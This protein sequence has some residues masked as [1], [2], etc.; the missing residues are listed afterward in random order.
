MSP[1]LQQQQQRVQQLQVQQWQWQQQQRFTQGP[2]P[3]VSRAD[4]IASPSDAQN[5]RRATDPG[6]MATQAINDQSNA[7][8]SL[9]NDGPRRTHSKSVPVGYTHP[10]SHEMQPILHQGPRQQQSPSDKFHHSLQYSQTPQSAPQS[11]QGFQQH[12]NFQH[13]GHTQP[14]PS[15]QAFGIHNQLIQAQQQVCSHPTQTPQHPPSSNQAVR[16][17][18][19]KS[20]PQN[21]QARAPPIHQ[22]ATSQSS[23]GSTFALEPPLKQQIVSQA[24]LPASQP[25]LTPSRTL[26]P[27]NADM[28]Q[29]ISRAIQAPFPFFFSASSAAQEVIPARPQ[30]PSQ[31]TPSPE[32]IADQHATSFLSGKA[33]PAFHDSWKS[34]HKSLSSEFS[35]L[36]HVHLVAIARTQEESRRARQ[37][38]QEAKEKCESA[39]RE[40]ERLF[41]IARRYKN[42][43]EE[44]NRNLM[45]MKKQYKV[46]CDVALQQNEL[47]RTSDKEA[48]KLDIPPHVVEV[49]VSGNYFQQRVIDLE[50]RLRKYED[51]SLA[52]A[53][54]ISSPASMKIE[55][56]HM[57]NGSISPTVCG[58]P[59]DATGADASGMDA[60]SAQHKSTDADEKQL[61]SE[62]SIV[63]ELI[64]RKSGPALPE[65]PTT[66]VKTEPMSK[67]DES[68]LL[69]EP[70]IIDLTN[71]DDSVSSSSKI[72]SSPQVSAS[73]R[74]PFTQLFSEPRQ[75]TSLSCKSASNVVSEPEARFPASAAGRPVSLP[76]IFP[77]DKETLKRG[78]Q[79]EESEE[80]EESPR[81]RR[82]SAPE[83]SES[84]TSFTSTSP[85]Q[86]SHV[87]PPP[88]GC[89]DMPLQRNLEGDGAVDEATKSTGVQVLADSLREGSENGELVE[90]R[91]QAGEGEPSV[92]LSDLH[93]DILYHR[94]SKSS[95][96]RCRMCLMQVDS[97][98]TEEKNAVVLPADAERDD[99]VQHSITAHAYAVV[100]LLRTDK[101]DL[102]STNRK[103]LNA[104]LS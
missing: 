44:S 37:S 73:P 51:P 46:V 82:C 9:Q 50:A 104:D 29:H 78:S 13:S 81:K 4:R 62:V 8:R 97:G 72:P 83:T 70:M 84:V 98:E 58:S 48:A 77:S 61:Q 18:S 92:E 1:H 38:E 103:L 85:V 19:A 42:H 26:T 66:T 56:V 55:M 16:T 96:Y 57:S 30:Q 90:T 65:A 95:E 94:S 15:N 101:A 93:M 36:N 22:Q 3:H 28:Q 39:T 76:P 45:E 5:A 43:A 2:Q 54:E 75:N 40:G 47:L 25:A 34:F 14:L 35:R 32:T 71:D 69:S 100:D 12:P 20:H 79:S 17:Q 67:D 63:S 102:I 41:K 87:Q 7:P 21:Q 27:L 6:S 24:Q 10:S 11:A 53:S 23:Q 99:L 59:M 80:S 68:R 33:W 89:F 91:N 64:E 31:P 86:S 74:A 60:S 52:D 88:T 49:L